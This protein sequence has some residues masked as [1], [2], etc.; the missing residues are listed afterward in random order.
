MKQS[1]NFLAFDMGAT[2]GRSI[3]GTLQDGKV[4]IKELT[5]FPNTMICIDNKFYWNIYS[6]FEE[7]KN[8]LRVAASEGIDLDSVGIDTW[9]VDFA[10]IA[11]DGSLLG[12]PR[13][14]RDLYT[15]GIPEEYFSSF[16]T[17]REVY[18]S[19][20]IQIMNFNS[21]FQLYAA[22]KQSVSA[23]KHAESVLFMPDALSYLLTGKKVCEYSIASTSQLLNAR[24]KKF[25][26]KLFKPVGITD[27]MMQP[28][29]MPG[30]FIGYISDSIAKECGINKVPVIAVAGHDTA[31]AVIAVPAENENF[32]YLS[33]GT[34][35]LMGIEVNDP[36]I[37]E[38]S[39]SINFT[40]EGGIDGTIRF[41]KNITGM[42]LLEQ[43]RKEWENSGKSYSYNEIVKL[44]DSVEKFRFIID[45]DDPSFANPE[46][47]TNAIVEYCKRTGQTT[48]Q[49][50]AEFI[51]AI[52]D[53]LALKYRYSLDCL[54]DMAPFKI[55]RLHIIGGGSQN[56]LLN[57]LTA[58]S[59]G[60]Q[61]M[62]G[63]TE[64]TAIGNLM[65]QAKGIG[66][67]NSLYEMRKI[68][69]DSCSP[70]IFNPDNSDI[71]D[72]TYK[73]YSKLLNNK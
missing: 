33:S 14:Y 12:L 25:E 51:R 66:V 11:E 5:R 69:K 18:E 34:W 36:I 42:W 6:L 58:N 71:W 49:T 26:N 67:V 35:S 22:K 3:L 54:Q 73:K 7:I 24:T 27:S 65:T 32:A 40:N 50:H 37:T 31:S 4:N 68:I 55:D 45:S 72:R 9:G 17:R 13:A 47:M 63:P 59:T 2:S 28:I 61:V 53:S 70:K 38:D 64:A 23:L 48:P 16:H 56:D 60:I 52:F 41:L 43:C 29:V 57:Q 20:G 15:N 21:L 1:Y 46:S 39:Y 19:T 10:Y 30:T 62:A 8:G 44:A